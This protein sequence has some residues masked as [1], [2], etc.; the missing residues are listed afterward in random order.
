MNDHP[1]TPM[2]GPLMRPRVNQPAAARGHRVLLATMVG[3][4]L[5]LPVWAGA[6][7]ALPQNAV[8][9]TQTDDGTSPRQTPET[10]KKETADLQG[11]QVTGSL[12]PRAQ[13]ETA[14]PTIQITAEQ[15]TRQGYATV[16]DALQALPQATG[17]VQGAQFSGG[18]TQAARTI[19]LLGL[20]PGFTL[21]LIDGKP[22]ADYP[23]LYN[24]SGNFVDISSIPLAMVDHIDIVPGNQSAIYGSSAIAGVVN[25]ILKQHVQGATLNFRGGGFSEGG[26]GSQRL[27]L[28]GGHDWDSTRMVYSVELGNQ[29]PIYRYQ[30]RWFD[31]TNDRPGLPAG[32]SRPALDYLVED[33][34]VGSGAAGRF[35]VPGGQASCARV[36]AGFGNSTVYATDAAGRGHYCGSPKSPA[37]ST[38]M[39]GT[40]AGT[41]YLNISHDLAPNTQLYANALLSV[42]KI[43][44][45]AG[46]NYTW[47]GSRTD[48]GPIY[49]SNVDNGTLADGPGSFVQTQY[50][51]DSS[52]AGIGNLANEKDLNRTYDANLGIRGTFANPDWAYDA[53]YHRSDNVITTR[54]LHLV[55][56][57]A[58]R[59]FLGDPSGLDP[60]FGT[61]PAYTLNLDRFYSVMS[62][63][64]YRS[65]SESTRTRSHAYT[66]E[67]TGTVTNTNLVDLP[68]GP[69]GLALLVQ[70]GDQRW[71]N[72]TDP[73]L[74]NGY[75]WGITGT[76]GAGSRDR[77]AA[78][79]EL[80]LPL[81]SRLT[82]SGSTR[83]DTYTVAGRTD[84]K[85]T[86]KLGL[87]WRPLDT[88]L[89]RGTYATAFRAPDM[90]GLFQG[91]S[92]FYT[93][94]VD[95][96][97]CRQQGGDNFDVDTCPYN[98]EQVS[99][100]Q[101]GNRDLKNITARSLTGGIVWSPSDKFTI[102]ADYYRILINNEVSQRSVDDIMSLEAD[103][104]IGHTVGGS[105]VEI[106]SPSCAEVLSLVD[107]NINP[108][109]P[110]QAGVDRVSTYPINISSERVSG[111]TAGAQ[112]RWDAG[113]AGD[114][115]LKADYNVTLKHDYRPYRGDP[116]LDLLTYRAF[117]RGFKH[118][119]NATINW[120]RGRLSATLHGLRNGPTMNFKQTGTV[121]PWIT[122]NASVRLQVN[123]EVQVS[124]ISNNVFNKR[125]PRDAGYTSYP[126][127]DGFNYNGYGRSIFAELEWKF[128]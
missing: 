26:G 84:S 36:S 55:A 2:D 119:E 46:S 14:T 62:P 28:T 40:K 58:N 102:H 91:E 48:L 75:F 13:V 15:I 95:Y 47:W 92:G 64:A 125:P 85:A 117:P 82:A 7:G 4:V 104:R 1:Y 22:M 18:F 30:R 83:Y 50:T 93:T 33:L 101:A 10:D 53:Y 80:S 77:Y 21:F 39:N 52:T 60:V 65:I 114:F 106:D 35:F 120:T 37:Y 29:R 68:G 90:A 126:Y 20:A 3:T 88:V 124:L 113:R 122:W 112:Y 86:Y 31:S 78:A 74:V 105:P 76:R 123:D 56:D 81:A 9:P 49:A 121:G 6:A 42:R 63:G 5:A 72:P 27:Q 45:Y 110:L 128:F 57:K 44:Y 59:Y 34:L 24:G 16:A 25:I 61:Y 73:R 97:R 100:T 38:I 12:L 32:Q 66:Q 41:G 71:E 99:G 118:R 116:F 87:E 103:C 107:R 96:Y 115:M 67:L 23:L 109:D 94:T 79:A 11:I 127:Y 111:I 98:N 8:T 70:Y 17:S 19:S 51:V 108:A 43:D 54:Q 69:A 89:L